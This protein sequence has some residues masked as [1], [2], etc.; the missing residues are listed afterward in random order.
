MIITKAASVIEILVI[1]LVFNNRDLCCKDCTTV[2][3]LD[4]LCY[5]DFRTQYNPCLCT[6]YKM[7]RYLWENQIVAKIYASTYWCANDIPEFLYPTSIMMYCIGTL[8]G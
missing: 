8:L 1:G 3:N 4:K 5:L 6:L 2:E 7:D